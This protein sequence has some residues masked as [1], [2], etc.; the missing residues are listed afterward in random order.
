[1]KI[2]FTDGACSGNPGPYGCAWMIDGVLK[3]TTGLNPA[4]NN[5]AEL[6]AIWHATQELYDHDEAVIFTDSKVC[7]S[8][9]TKN[10]PCQ[11]HK[12]RQEMWNYVQQHDIHIHFKRIAGKNCPQA[13]A[14][15]KA[16][17]AA[18][19]KNVPVKRKLTEYIAEQ[20]DITDEELEDD[21]LP[22]LMGMFPGGLK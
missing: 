8:W 3:T 18:I 7:V 12:L 16:A 5:L 11:Y 2:I 13:V 9:L 19:V 10:I 21:V 22:F 1:M 20:N 17:K 15:D 14:V 6:E 4:T